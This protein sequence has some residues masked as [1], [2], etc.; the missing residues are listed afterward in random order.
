VTVETRNILVGAVAF[1]IGAVF[2][3]WSSRGGPEAEIRGYEIKALYQSIDGVTIGTDVNLVGLKVGSVVGIDFVPEGHQAQLTFRID[4]NIELPV[5]SVA[6]IVSA[7]MLGGK[8]IK[9]EPGGEED[10]LQNGDFLEYVQD[11]IIFEELLQKIVLDA[12][13][14]RKRKN[15][16]IVK[17]KKQV[18]EPKPAKSPFGSL[19]K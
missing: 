1:L 16:G 13:A 14:K 12:E 6:M 3:V 19:L 9:L 5:D 8:Y 17:M 15:A 18:S 4:S 7:S 11:A 10:M 2:L